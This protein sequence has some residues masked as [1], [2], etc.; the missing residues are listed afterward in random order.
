[1]PKLSMPSIVKTIPKN[2]IYKW[3]H[4]AKSEMSKKSA[5]YL[6]WWKNLSGNKNQYLL[7]R[8]VTPFSVF[9]ICLAF[10]DEILWYSRG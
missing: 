3:R 9:V 8:G 5:E 4:F 1:M 10:L 7:F 6:Q 2:A